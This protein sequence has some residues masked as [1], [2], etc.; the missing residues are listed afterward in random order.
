ML[1]L[2]SISKSFPGVRALDGVSLSF[3]PGQIHALVGE[4]G[5]GKSTLLKIITGVH[6][7]DAG[8]VRL[9]GHRLELH[10]P[11]DAFRRGIG[12]VHQ[13]IQLIPEAGIGENVL[14][15]RLPR[16]GWSRRVDWAEVSR[17]ATRFLRQVGLDLPAETPVKH[18]SAAQKQLVQIA[19]ALSAD[20]RV[21]LLDEP[22]SSLTEHEARNLSGI[23]R[24]LREEGVAVVYVSHKLDE[25]RALADRISVLRDGR[26]VATEPAAGLSEQD[27]VRLMIGRETATQRF[28]ALKP[29]HSREALR[30]RGLSKRG[31]IEDCSFTLHPGEILGFYGLV[32]SGRTETARLIIGDD[33][34][35]RGEVFVRG[36]RAEIRSV[37]DSLHRYRIGYVSENRKEEGLL[38]DFTV[39]MN[40][41]ITVWERLRRRLTRRIDPQAEHEIGRQMVD[42]LAIKCTGLD[43]TTG[44]LSGGN[45]QKICMAKWL[46]ARCDILIIDE[47]TVG[48]DVGA[49]EQIHQLIWDLAA[50][51]GR[52]VILISSDMPE[53]IRL[54]HRILV[55]RDRRVAGEVT[56]LDEPGRSEREI[57]EAIGAFLT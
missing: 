19:R 27:I 14:L 43:Q 49:K 1:E 46:A 28:G 52:A 3:A 45:Q 33:R 38:L 9:D 10:S 40:I 32:G 47:P 17:R 7:P 55:F 30:V 56:G 23:L 4:N 50:K 20:A 25:V 12:I 39:G 26:H 44:T 35:E 2:R 16:R 53:M 31:C 6:Q 21:L 11:Q 22:T 57:C 24:R 36:E 37:H 13:E 54:A 41:T 8:E 48:V 34:P 42:A 15:D 51:E 29:D 5:A 18:L